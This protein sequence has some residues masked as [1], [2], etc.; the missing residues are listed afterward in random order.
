[1]LMG[2]GP[3]MIMLGGKFFPTRFAKQ[4]HCKRPKSGL[5]SPFSGCFSKVWRRVH[6]LGQ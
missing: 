5:K 4:S 6:A 2:Q 1:M 3:M